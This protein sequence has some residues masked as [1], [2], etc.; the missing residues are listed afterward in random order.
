MP[1]KPT[2]HIQKTAPGPPR[3]I[4]SRHAADIAKPDRCGQ[5]R[6]QGL[7]VIDRAGIVGFVVSGRGSHSTVGQGPIL[8]RSRS[9]G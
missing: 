4:A 7:E 5:C 1:R 3:D 9:T 2:I 6:R 8:A